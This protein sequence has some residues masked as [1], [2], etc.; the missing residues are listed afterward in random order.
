MGICPRCRLDDNS[1]IRTK[2]LSFCFHVWSFCIVLSF[3]VYRSSS[4]NLNVTF[5]PA[6]FIPSVYC[7]FIRLLMYV[8]CSSERNVR[9]SL[10]ECNVLKLSIEELHFVALI[11]FRL[12]LCCDLCARG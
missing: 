9:S 7:L 6:S 10:Y 5:G 1:G 8:M 2:I 11:H 4:K 3:K 12:E